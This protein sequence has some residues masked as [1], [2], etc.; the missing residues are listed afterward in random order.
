MSKVGSW[1]ANIWQT[2]AIAYTSS[3]PQMKYARDL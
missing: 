2:R 1:P 3:V